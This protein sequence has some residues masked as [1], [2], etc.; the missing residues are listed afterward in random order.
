MWQNTEFVK[1]TNW[2]TLAAHW[3]HFQPQSCPFLLPHLCYNVNSTNADLVFLQWVQ[4]KKTKDSN[5][6]IFP[7]NLDWK[8]SGVWSCDHSW[9]TWQGTD[10]TSF[11]LSLQKELNLNSAN[12]CEVTEWSPWQCRSYQ[13]S[14][15]S[16]EELIFH[17]VIIEK[18][19]ASAHLLGFFSQFMYQ[20]LTFQEYQISSHTR[21]I[22]GTLISK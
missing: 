6:T 18:N 1:F 10:T 16:Q 19:S 5:F 9:L 2:S 13:L 20:M 12:K 4:K 14:Q 3:S 8:T 17:H 7:L 21:H 22:K 15:R 11:S